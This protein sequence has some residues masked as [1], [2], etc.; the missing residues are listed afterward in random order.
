MLK[1]YYEILNVAENAT[2][3]EIK[4]QYKKLVKM[5]HPDVNSSFEAEQVFKDIN[6]AA[7]I[8][9]DD[10]KRKN[11][12]KLRTLSENTS[13][14]YT[15]PR[16]SQYSFYDLFKKQK[17]EE[18]KHQ[19]PKPIKGQDINMEVEIDYTEALLGTTR[20]INISK[21]TLCPKCQGH[22][23]ANGQKCTYCDGKGEKTENKK[24]TIKIP[25]GLKNGSKLRIK[26]EGQQGKF[27][28]ENGNLYIKVNIEK[29]GELDIK[30]EIVYYNA[31]ISPYTAVL[32]GNVSI[33]TLWGEAMIKIPPLT[34]ANQSFKLIDV[35]I[36]NDKT[37]KKGDMIVKIIIQIPD[38]I[39]AQEQYLYEKLRNIN[40]NKTNGKTI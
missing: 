33:P 36:L 19:V 2:K 7:E 37:G 16:E 18:H 10:I 5:Y 1:S 35:G 25:K 13:K 26:G 8:L 29:K 21:C 28:G 12:D 30:D 22:K 32:G 4:N 23:F 31:Q 9:L 24:I 34:K 40:L 14:S 20:S 3:N 17:N 11:Y 39:T 38:N 6:R 27:G 15:N